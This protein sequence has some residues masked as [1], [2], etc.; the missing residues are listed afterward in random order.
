VNQSIEHVITEHAEMRYMQRKP[1]NNDLISG[2]PRKEIKQFFK[3]SKQIEWKNRRNKAKYFPP[4]ELAFAYKKE[5]GR[6]IIVTVL[7][8]SEDEITYKTEEEPVK[9]AQVEYAK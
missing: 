1:K 7:R 2:N 6:H 4:L 9:P 3:D 5:K 8:L